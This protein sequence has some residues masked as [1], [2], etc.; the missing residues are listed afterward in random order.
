MRLQRAALGMHFPY[1]LSSVHSSFTTTVASIMVTSYSRTP[2]RQGQ[3]SFRSS[4][5]PLGTICSRL[6]PKGT[7]D[8]TVLFAFSL[9]LVVF[10]RALTGFGVIED[11]SCPAHLPRLLTTPSSLEIELNASQS[12]VNVRPP[13]VQGLLYDTPP[14]PA[15]VPQDAFPDPTAAVAAIQFHTG[16]VDPPHPPLQNQK[17]VPLQGMPFYRNAPYDPYDLE[18]FGGFNDAPDAGTADIQAS[19]RSLASGEA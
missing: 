3:R 9:C 19:T 8:R 15:A 4:L 18:Y 17:Y 14:F 13:H 11:A 6:L 10:L 1:P 7:W 2:R 16:R 12:V 5:Q